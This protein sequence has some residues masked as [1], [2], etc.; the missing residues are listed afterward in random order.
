MKPDAKTNHMRI[1]IHYLWTLHNIWIRSEHARLLKNPITLHNNVL[2]NFYCILTHCTKPTN[3]YVITEKH[4]P[5]S[6][7]YSENAKMIVV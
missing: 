1:D 7:C 6:V 5:G 4:Q 3:C 2:Y